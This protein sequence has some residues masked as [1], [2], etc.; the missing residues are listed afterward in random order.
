MIRFIAAP[1]RTSEVET[2]QT[3]ARS[4]LVVDDERDMCDLIVDFLGREGYEVEAAHT[5]P[6]ALARV[7]EQDY[8]VVVTDLRMPGM[9]GIE[10][11]REVKAL[12]PD[13]PVILITAFG[14]IDLAIEAMKAGAFYFVTKPFKM[15]QLEAL[16]AKAAEQRG[17]VLENRRL[18]R[19]VQGHYEPDRIIGHSRAMRE[20]FRMVDLVADSYSNVLIVGESGT[21]KEMIA[22]AIH[23]RS[24][25]AQGPFVPVNC[26]AIPEG[27]L[28]SELF[29][30]M[31]GAFTGAYSS[32]KGLFVEASGGTLFLDEIGDM[33]LA[34]QAK[35]LRVLQ[36]RVVRPVG[37]NKSFSTDARVIAATH[38]DL[39]AAVREGAFREDL[40]YRL[41]VIPLRIPPL[42]ER[43]EDVPLL[44]DHFLEKCATASGRPRKRI[45][46]R[47]VAALQRRTWEGNVRELENIIERLVVLTPGDT[48]DV[49]DL[50][51]AMAP[52]GSRGPGQ[53][54]DDLPTLDEM[55]RR[56]V[57]QVL[58]RTS[59][60]KEKAARILG[61][62]RRTLYRMQ[63]RWA[64]RPPR[65]RP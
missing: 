57:L 9:D 27:L 64:K 58:D 32:R 47:A 6:E 8:D 3:K 19:E 52:E 59:G 12:R 22:R 23:F 13:V 51:F 50:P 30:H 43:A 48:V 5:G 31:R 62:N 1:G 28:E 18:R 44:V 11:L 63:E 16:V 39:K 7:R 17:L 61:I 53:G 60:N 38:R 21:G 56:Y 10:V 4:V 49:D 2:S 25:R 29:G 20:I 41:S 55:E 40:Y 46:A 45:T 35:L 33:G 15:R 65:T 42:S 26:S 24:R 54:P 14:S 36:D 37:S 34:L